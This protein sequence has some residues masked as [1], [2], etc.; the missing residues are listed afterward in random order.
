MQEVSVNTLGAMLTAAVLAASGPSATV[1]SAPPVVV[2]TV[3]EAGSEGVDP[4]TSEIRVTFS[5]VMKD[6]EWSW[7]KVPDAT[8]PTAAGQPRYEK[9]RRTCVLPVKLDPGQT[10]GVWVNSPS[11]QNFRDAGGRSA[12]PYLLV[13][14]TRGKAGATQTRNDSIAPPHQLPSNTALQRTIGLPRFA[15]AA[16]RR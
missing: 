14:A 16:I 12:V 11:A 13:F 6:G 8:F 3:P 4:A 7:Y 9:D 5:K 2:K 15:R 10:Y 1:A